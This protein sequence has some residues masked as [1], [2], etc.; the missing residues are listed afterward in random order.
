MVRM[1]I[2][3]HEFSD[4]NLYRVV[5]DNLPDMVHSVDSDG[6]IIYANKAAE[7]LL[8]YSHDELIGMVIQDLYS[9]SIRDKVASGFTE[10]KQSGDKRVESLLYTKDKCE[11][12]VEIR[13]FGVYNDKGE[14]VH[15]FSILR[16]L[17]QVKQLQ[18]ELIHAGRLAAIGE[19][20]AGIVHDINN[21]VSSIQL[22]TSLQEML[23]KDIEKSITK[24][25]SEALTESTRNIQRALE[26]IKNLCTHLRGFA[27]KTVDEFCPLNLNQ[28]IK[29]ACF[30]C[31]FKMKKNKVVL[32]NQ[33]PDGQY[34]TKGSANQ[35]EQLFANLI[36]N[37]CDA[38]EGLKKRRIVTLNIVPVERN[39]Q[40][41]WRCDVSDTGHGMPENVKNHIFDS[42][43]TTKPKGSG[44]GLGLSICRGIIENHNGKM[45]VVSEVDQGTSFFVW[46][47]KTE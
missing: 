16:D 6:K 33:I 4:V 42:F 41:Y 26:S 28:I 3:Q 27:R 44:T 12:P 23:L 46:L 21:P 31:E 39:G 38:M 30:L 19:M 22:T 45:D 29:D 24:N 36:G 47:K 14:F 5:L 10:L 20:A 37:A 17:R 40:A 34:L 25:D 8:G 9:P 43:F 13:S 32:D 35:L 11:V 7:N 15:T 18:S 2:N 1:R